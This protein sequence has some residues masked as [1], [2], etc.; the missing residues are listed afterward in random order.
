M[1][2]RQKRIVIDEISTSD[3]GRHEEK[4]THLFVTLISHKLA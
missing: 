1:V 4:S 3:V 2:E